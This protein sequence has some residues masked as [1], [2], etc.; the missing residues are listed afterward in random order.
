MLVD[1]FRSSRKTLSATLSLVDGFL[2]PSR[3]TLSATQEWL[4][5]VDGSLLPFDDLQRIW[6]DTDS[7]FQ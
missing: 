7:T 3:N 5:L 6:P 4:S 2:L 1:A